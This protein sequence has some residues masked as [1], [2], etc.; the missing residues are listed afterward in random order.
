[1]LE[2]HTVQREGLLTERTRRNPQW[3]RRRHVVVDEPSELSVPHR[4]PVAG[5]MVRTGEA[6]PAMA[7]WAAWVVVAT[8]IPR[9][10][11]AFGLRRPGWG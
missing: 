11:P 3:S 8:N 10:I 5:L 6:T 1:V 7:P 4:G 9:T 2:H